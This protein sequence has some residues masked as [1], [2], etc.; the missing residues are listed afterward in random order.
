[1]WSAQCPWP[2]PY[3]VC[4]SKENLI[5]FLHVPYRQRPGLPWH[6]WSL[7]SFFGECASLISLTLCLAQI[8]AYTLRTSD[9]L[10]NGSD[11]PKIYQFASSS[12]IEVVVTTCGHRCGPGLDQSCT[13]Y[14]LYFSSFNAH[15]HSRPFS[16]FQV[17]TDTRVLKS[18]IRSYATP[19]FPPPN[20]FGGR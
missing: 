20:L 1:M 8:F 15:M 7:I 4:W 5:R 17:N 13:Y 9:H 18:L 3:F 10:F 19:R 6:A 11:S 16:S 2:V 14:C 12:K